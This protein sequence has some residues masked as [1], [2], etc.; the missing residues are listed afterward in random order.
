[1]ETIKAGEPLIDAIKLCYQA[2]RPALLVGRHGVGKSELL[3]EAADELGVDYIARDLSLMEPADL[4]GLPRAN[5]KSTIYLPP[6]FLPR[7]G[8]G[9]LAFEE[10]NRCE[11]YMRAPC[12]QLLTERALND[13]RLPEGWL[14]VAAVNPSTADYEVAELDPA[15]VSRFVRLDVEPDHDQWLDWARSKGIHPAVTRYVEKDKTVFDMPESNPRAWKYI[16][17]LL[18]AANKVGSPSAPLRAAVIGLVG[19]ERGVAFLQTL[20]NGQMPLA[21]NDIL[22]GYSRRRSDILQWIQQ[23]RIDLVRS[24]LLAVQ[25]FLQPAANYEQMKKS[26]SQWKNLGS[27]L[28]DLPGDLREEAEA[29]F[30]AR[31]YSVPKPPKGKRK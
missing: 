26:R 31:G 2:D 27:F 3:K 24:T 17:D 7:N 12:L 10:L 4:T 16:S 5:G 23:G 9:L 8:K 29:D 20:T 13:Y 19:D 18:Q 1:M 15:L 22:Q 11:P 30:K 25:K 21:A 28:A 14:P 6:S